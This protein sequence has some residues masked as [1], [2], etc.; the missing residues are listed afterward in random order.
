MRREKKRR[1]ASTWVG[2]QRASLFASVHFH[3]TAA[4]VW[5]ELGCLVNRDTQLC[6]QIDQIDHDLHQINQIDHDLDQIDHDL[7]QIDHDLHQIDHDLHQTDH[8]PD[9]RDPNPP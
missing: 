8:D 2:V 1:R 5:L 7:D 9:H 3:A 6:A 4:W